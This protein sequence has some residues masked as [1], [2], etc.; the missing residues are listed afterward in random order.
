MRLNRFFI[1]ALIC[2]SAFS[3]LFGD[4][5]VVYRKEFKGTFEGYSKGKFQFRLEDGSD[6]SELQSK[7]S[8]LALDSPR[9]V[10]L[11]RARQKNADAVQFVGYQGLR[12]VFKVGEKTVSL[13][14]P[15]VIEISTGAG[16]AVQ[17]NPQQ[18]GNNAAAVQ[19]PKLPPL[20]APLPPRG[21]TGVKYSTFTTVANAEEFVALVNSGS[22]RIFLLPGN[23]RLKNPVVLQ[24]NREFMFHGGDRMRT[25]FLASDPSQPMFIVNNL[26]GLSLAGVSLSGDNAIASPAIHFVNK[27]P[28]R[29]SMIDGFTEKTYLNITG[30]GMFTVQSCSLKGGDTLPAPVV[31]DH[32]QADFFMIGG[33]IACQA[34]E[35]IPD[36]YFH[37]WQKR[38]RLRVYSTGVQ[39]AKG[40]ADFRIDTASAIGPHVIANIRS[41]GHNVNNFNNQSC[42]LY[43]PESAEKVDVVV[44]N[45]GAS[46]PDPN[47]SGVMV[48]YSAAGTV[49]LIGNNGHYKARHLFKGKAPNATLVALGNLTHAVYTAADINVGKCYLYGNIFDHRFS[50][51]MDQGQPWFRHITDN[52]PRAALDEMPRVPDLQIPLPIRRPVCDKPIKGILNVKDPPYNA[53][54]DGVTDDGGA[55]WKALNDSPSVYLPE[56]TYLISGGLWVNSSFS[57]SWP[58]GSWIA[59]AGSDK[60]KIVCAEGFSGPTFATEG[61]AYATIQGITFKAPPWANGANGTHNVRLENK[62][63][64]G[65]A[66]QEIAFHDCH[67]IGGYYALGIGVYSPTMCSENMMVGCTFED[68]KYGIAVGNYN[69]LANV[70]Y[71]CAFTN[72]FITVGQSDGMSGGTVHLIHANITGTKNSDLVLF[73]SAS[74]VMFFH[75][76]KSDSPLF[77]SKGYGGDSY[78]LLLEYCRLMPSAASGALINYGAIGG[79]ILIDTEMGGN[80]Q[81]NRGMA[82]NFGIGVR[83]RFMNGATGNGGGAQWPWLEVK[84]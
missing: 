23:Y 80:V 57:K 71:D 22:Q 60:T 41:E 70:A 65:H 75:G 78:S 49:W 18:A 55:L 32:P 77:V 56:G 16:A 27:V 5:M 74:A 39:V 12:F 52:E 10:T 40:R 63:G 45:N 51:F 54:G 3:L 26:R 8:R 69:S 50:N 81:I 6:G 67:F 29:F 53:K 42:F 30:P 61:L 20:P 1:A 76:V 2:L 43:V 37:L 46:W 4:V 62:D 9:D 35:F 68:A 84:K 7:V 17:A 73:R 72:N 33:N 44:K 15:D 13:G 31:I 79:P 66:T 38:G 24:G 58:A 83:T 34:K 25:K 47:G 64:V 19:A 59:G 82:G 14:K 11:L 28:T 21:P 36:A 48:D